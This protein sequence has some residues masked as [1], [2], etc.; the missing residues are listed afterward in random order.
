M[1]QWIISSTELIFFNS[2]AQGGLEWKAV[3]LPPVERLQNAGTLKSHDTLLLVP[4]QPLPPRIAIALTILWIKAKSL[5]F[6]SLL[7]P[8]VL[9]HALPLGPM[10]VHVPGFPPA[11]RAAHFQSPWGAPAMCCF[12]YYNNSI[13]HSSDSEAGISGT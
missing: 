12:I 3:C 4:D 5:Y 2:P 10:V 8:L 13:K 6:T 11:S 9:K 1:A 7:A